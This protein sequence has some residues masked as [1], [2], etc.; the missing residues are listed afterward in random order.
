M[1]VHTRIAPYM[2]SFFERLLAPFRA[3]TAQPLHP[4]D[5]P[6]AEAPGSTVEGT[7]FS[8][9]QDVAATQAEQTF[10]QPYWLE[11]E[12]ILRDEGVLFGLSESDSTEKVAVIRNYFAYLATDY[13]Q[14]I[15]HQN[16]RIQ[17]QNL[18]IGQKEALKAVL[19]AKISQAEEALA[20]VAKESHLVRI[21]VGLL[22]AIAMCVGNYMLID[23]TLK[24]SF[25]TSPL[26]ALGVFMAGMF[27]LFGRYSLFHEP[28]LQ[29][30]ARRLL[31]EVGMPFAAALFVFVQAW[32]TQP[33]PV[34]LALLVFVFFVFLFAGK[35]LLSTLS[36]LGK[37]LPDHLLR[38]RLRK[39][40]KRNILKWEEEVQALTEEIDELRV[41]RWKLLHQQAQTES[42]RDKLYA[43]RDA[44]IQAFESEFSLARRMKHLLT[45]Q[46]LRTIN[47][48]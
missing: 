45:T 43:Q 29:L 18:F 13:E 12:D 33:L 14:D 25:A 44:R 6:E 26:I 38:S 20:P 10:E 8:A 23:H 39:E 1:H 41:A 22:L 32:M 21:V 35:L 2:A 34:A 47:G 4:Y 48:Q 15:L 36:L 7:G 19:E 42:L 3:A 46:E 11:N 37:E 40:N 17:E 30:N 24:P 5:S 16:E 27:N 9:E 31:E 28:D